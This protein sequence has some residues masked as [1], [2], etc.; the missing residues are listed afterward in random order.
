[1]EKCQFGIS[2][3][4]FFGQTITETGLNPNKDKVQKFLY[5]IKMPKTVKQV[6]KFIGFNQYF[7]KFTPQLAVKLD[8]FSSH[9]LKM[10]NSLSQM[11]TALLSM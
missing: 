2:Q 3:I 6:R 11:N 7:Q 1:M 10:K 9:Y 8:L 4:Q 5:N